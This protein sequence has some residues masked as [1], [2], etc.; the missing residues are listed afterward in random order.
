[1]TGYAVDTWQ[2]SGRWAVVTWCPDLL[3]LIHDPVIDRAGSLRAYRDL[4]QD[5]VCSRHGYCLLKIEWDLQPGADGITVVVEQLGTVPGDPA[6]L[7]RIAGHVQEVAWELAGAPQRWHQ[8]VQRAQVVHTPDRVRQ[9][10][11]LAIVVQVE[12]DD[13]VRWIDVDEDEHRGLW[14]SGFVTQDGM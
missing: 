10:R 7:G 3:G 14:S 13:G 8:R 6:V 12:D 4:V 11:T 5:E 9:P 2:G 1:M